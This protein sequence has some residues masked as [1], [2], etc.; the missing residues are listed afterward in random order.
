MKKIIFLTKCGGGIGIGVLRPAN[1]YGH[2]ETRPR[3]KVSPKIL[4]NSEVELTTP[5]LHGEKH[6]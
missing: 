1:S 4:E 3:F 2:M 6:V 5:G